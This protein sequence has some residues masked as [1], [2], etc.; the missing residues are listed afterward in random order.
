MR[1][2]RSKMSRHADVAKA[3]DYMLKP[4]SAGSSLEAGCRIDVTRAS[5]VP[6]RLHQGRCVQVRG[7]D[8]ERRAGN[9][10][11]VAKGA[12]LD[13]LAYPVAGN[14]ALLSCLAQGQPGP[15]L[16][17][18]DA[19]DTAD[20]ADPVRCPGLTLPGWQGYPVESG[21]DVVIGPAAGH[22]A[23]DRQ[24]VFGG[25]ACV[26]ARAGLTQAQF[27]VLSAFPMDDQNDLPYRLVDIDDD[28]VVQR[29][30]QLLAAARDERIA[31]EFLTVMKT[32]KVRPTSRSA[33][34]ISLAIASSECWI[35][36][37]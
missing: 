32:G 17:G 37:R 36:S 33:I 27:R 1:I 2:A 6:D 10:L 12:G 13:Q 29:A 25:A 19:A 5:F 18:M 30:H 23:N 21:S 8:L 22:A 26:F 31:P 7:P 15:V 14:A 24:G 9:N 35:T 4:P 3:I 34:P 20:R 11:L 16:L 28:L